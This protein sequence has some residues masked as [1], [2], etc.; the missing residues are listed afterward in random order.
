MECVNIKCEVGSHKEEL[1]KYI[2]DIIEA[3]ER[4]TEK[5][6]PYRNVPKKKSKYKAS[7]RKLILECKEHVQP[8]KDEANFWY[9]EWRSA[10]KERSGF[11]YD[12]MRFS[13]NK[14][15]YSKRKV[16]NAAEALKRDKFLEAALT[17]D[18]DFFEELKK[19]K[20]GAPKVASKVDGY[21]DADSIA[22]HLP[23]K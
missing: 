23:G 10:G 21:T 2:L 13:R 18:K 9:L 17:G 11:L 14:F 19:L 22:D 16:L 6:I 20:G 4:T 12:N 15:R 7:C 1:D 8:L 5:T 3:I